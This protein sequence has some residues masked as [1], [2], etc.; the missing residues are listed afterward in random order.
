MP[1][2]HKDDF[3][4]RYLVRNNLLDPVVKAFIDNGPRYNLLNRSVPALHQHLKLLLHVC[5]P[6]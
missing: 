4:N 1:A 2:H 5:L 6:G 3:Y